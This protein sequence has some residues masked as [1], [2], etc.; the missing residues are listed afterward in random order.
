LGTTSCGAPR[1]QLRERR[2]IRANA[3]IE[4]SASPA[5][6]RPSPESNGAGAAVFAHV[7]S[8]RSQR[9]SGPLHAVSQQTPSAQK[10]DAHTEP[11]SHAAPFGFGVGVTV[12]VAVTVPVAVTVAVGVHVGGHAGC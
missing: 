9:S 10:V 6:A 1:R 5:N 3:A 8:R 4:Q 11:V 12:G 7:P 2:R